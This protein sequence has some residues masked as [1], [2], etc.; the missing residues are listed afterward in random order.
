MSCLNK[1][2]TDQNRMSAEDKESLYSKVKKIADDLLDAGVRIETDYREG[3]SPGWKFNDWELKGIPLRLEFGP[4]DAEKGVVTTSR[5]DIDDKDAA[6][7]T[8]NVDALTK[9]VPALLEKIQK[10]M[11]DRALSLRSTARTLCWFPT[12]RAT[13]VKTRSRQRAPGQPLVTVLQKTSRPLLWVRRACVFLSS[14]PPVSRRARQS[15]S[16]PT[17]RLLRNNGFSLVGV[18]SGR[19]LETI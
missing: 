10:D 19:L 1:G 8:I 18:I 4:K 16:T 12:A 3:Y 2:L 14:S 5:R 13:S 6:R 17:A 9:E 7:G 11:F 15:A